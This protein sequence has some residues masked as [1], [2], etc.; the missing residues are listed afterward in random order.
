[1]TSTASPAAPAAP[2]A[3][4]AM[5]SPDNI[6]PSVL[7]SPRFFDDETLS[8]WH[9]VGKPE[10]SQVAC[11]VPQMMRASSDMEPYTSMVQRYYP[12]TKTRNEENGEP[13]A[14][15]IV[16]GFDNPLDEEWKIVIDGVLQKEGF[17]YRK[18][19]T[20]DRR[21]VCTL[22]RGVDSVQDDLFVRPVVIAVRLE[23]EAIAPLSAKGRMYQTMLTTEHD[24]T[25]TEDVLAMGNAFDVKVYRTSH[26]SSDVVKLP[27]PMWIPPHLAL[28]I[29]SFEETMRKAEI[30]SWK[31]GLSLIAQSYNA[32][33]QAFYLGQLK[34]FTELKEA[35][36]ANNA[37]ISQVNNVI[38]VANNLAPGS[39]TITDVTL[40]KLKATVSRPKQSRRFRVESTSS[41]SAQR[42]V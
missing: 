16:R 39:N 38:R 34:K 37:T 1:M 6:P 24:N 10:N 35:N 21:F 18:D 22:P 42:E 12:D 8:A 26:S 31:N 7:D 19:P 13:I 11:T 3:T 27:Y 9:V 2:A 29:V 20:N 32:Y 41:D 33:N 17:A 23:N 5:E 36:D 14:I 40:K 15:E 30:E 28:G 25:P 4:A